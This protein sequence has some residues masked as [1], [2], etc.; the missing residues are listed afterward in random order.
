LSRMRTRSGEIILWDAKKGERI[1][2]SEA[3]E[4]P[5]RPASTGTM[6]WYALEKL[7]DLKKSERALR[8]EWF[9]GA[10]RMRALPSRSRVP[11]WRACR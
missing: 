4:R 5:E 8:A 2:Q 10:W 7:R 3:P 11:A 6:Q 9:T 1:G